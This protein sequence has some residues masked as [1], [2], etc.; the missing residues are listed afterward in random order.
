MRTLDYQVRV[1]DAVDTY[2]DTL[3]PELAKAEKVAALAAENPDIGLAP[4][5][6]PKAAWDTLHAAGRLPP[7]RANVP[8]SPR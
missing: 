2:L 4:P 8:F 7:S 5:D 3:M 1:L 6:F